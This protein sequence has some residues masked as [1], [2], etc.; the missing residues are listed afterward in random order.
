MKQPSIRKVVIAA[1]VLSFMPLGL[2]RKATVIKERDP[3]TL[4]LGPTELVALDP[5]TQYHASKI[6][7]FDATVKLFAA[8]QP[9]FS[10]I[11]L[12]PIYVYGPNL[13]G[14]GLGVANNFLLSELS[15]ETPST[16]QFSGVH[17]SDVAVAHLKA[18][19]H[20]GT[21]IQSYLLAGRDWPWSDVHAFLNAKYPGSEFKLQPR[22]SMVWRF[23]ARR[24]QQELGLEF[25]EMEVQVRDVMQ[26][27]LALQ[28]Q[29]GA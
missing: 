14:G 13:H 25:Q 9:S 23:D 16:D 28:K 22:D 5:I 29:Q 6:A 1:S 27:Y 3:P 4:S 15:S 12:H 8:R 7:S 17:V 18:L 26:Q 10:I 11:T 20:K 24:A 21:G 2:E 19:D